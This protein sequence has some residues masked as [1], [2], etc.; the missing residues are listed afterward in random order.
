MVQELS[1]IER[2]KRSRAL[3][4]WAPVKTRSPLASVKSTW[5]VRSAFDP[6]RVGVL[7]VRFE[8]VG[9]FDV[10]GAT[11]WNVRAFERPE[12]ESTVT[13]REPSDALEAMMSCAV[14][15]FPDA[16]GLLIV[17]PS[18]GVT[19]TALTVAISVPVIMKLLLVCPGTPMR[20]LIVV[21]CGGGGSLTSK[22]SPLERPAGEMTVTVRRPSGAS[23]AIATCAV[24][25]KGLAF[26][27]LTVTPS[28]GINSN[29]VTPPS[30]TPVIARLATVRPCAPLSGCMATI[31]GAAGRC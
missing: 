30:G 8:T 4:A 12:G 22:L 10:G 16:T 14:T 19:S 18:P 13:E 28:G 23:A 5:P 1:P 21:I 3:V 24:T 6:T 29:P 26:R 11:T 15:E 31:R 7:T 20:W 27:L 2:T 9:T 25:P 17:T